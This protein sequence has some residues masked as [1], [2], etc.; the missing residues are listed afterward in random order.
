MEMGVSDRGR[1]IPGKTRTLIHQSYVRTQIVQVK[2]VRVLPDFMRRPAIV[3]SNFDKGGD[4]P[5]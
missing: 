4:L 2:R 1:N 5:G 3:N